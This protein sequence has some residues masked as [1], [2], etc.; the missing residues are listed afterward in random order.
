MER[1]CKYDLNDTCLS[2]IACCSAEI[3][4]DRSSKKCIHP[5]VRLLEG[6]VYQN[7][8]LHFLGSNGFK[9]LFCISDVSEKV[10]QNRVERRLFELSLHF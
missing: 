4:A 2:C 3:V 8:Y 10:E 6:C 1:S 5:Y 9:I 7:T